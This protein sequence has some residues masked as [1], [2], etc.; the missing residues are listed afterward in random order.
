MVST[1]LSGPEGGPATLSYTEDTRWKNIS[2]RNYKM[3]QVCHI[4]SCQQMDHANFRLTA[5]ITHGPNRI[6]LQYFTELSVYCI[7]NLSHVYIKTSI[8]T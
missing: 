2:Q 8:S 4:S 7:T 1:A 3:F 5:F 6:N